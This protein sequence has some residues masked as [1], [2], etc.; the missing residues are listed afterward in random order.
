[1]QVLSRHEE[2]WRKGCI[3][4]KMLSK[5]L[6][7]PTDLV[8]DHVHGVLTHA[9]ELNTWYMLITGQNFDVSEKKREKRQG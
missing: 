6:C 2:V 5:G 9:K 8:A 7:G 4:A 1:M 3:E